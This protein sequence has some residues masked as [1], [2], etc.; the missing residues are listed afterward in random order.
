MLTGGSRW[1]SMRY[2]GQAVQVEGGTGRGGQ[3]GLGVARWRLEGRGG[4]RWEL[5][6]VGGGQLCQVGQVR[7]GE[8]V[9][10]RWGWVWPC[11]GR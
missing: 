2:V 1:G 7:E 5:V 11:G 3:V 9:R 6:G 4:A 8:W 10:W